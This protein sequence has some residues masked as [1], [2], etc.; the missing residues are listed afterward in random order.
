MF[1]EETVSKT[2]VIQISQ[3][4]LAGMVG[5]GGISPMPSVDQSTYSAMPV[6]LDEKNVS[7]SW[8]SLC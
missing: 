6:R 5:L 7:Y 3:D 8:I 2:E 4:E 1:L